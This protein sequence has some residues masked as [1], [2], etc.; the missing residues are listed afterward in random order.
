MS[1]L[2]RNVPQIL[3]KL[4]ASFNEGGQDAIKKLGLSH[5]FMHIRKIQNDFPVDDDI[6]FFDDS[7]ENITKVKNEAPK[8]KTVLINW[9]YG[10][11]VFEFI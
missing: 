11:S 6:V 4:H 9:R 2:T 3:G 7:I 5:F 8:I 10:L 1:I